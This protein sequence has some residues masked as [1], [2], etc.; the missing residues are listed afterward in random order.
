VESDSATLSHLTFFRVDD[1]GNL[2]RTASSAIA[3]AANGVV[4]I[5][6]K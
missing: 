1:D 6:T 5:S 3:S 2:A 4:I